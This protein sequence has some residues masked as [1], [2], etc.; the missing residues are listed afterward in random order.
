MKARRILCLISGVH[1]WSGRHLGR[2]SYIDQVAVEYPTSIGRVLAVYRPTCN[3]QSAAA[4]HRSMFGHNQ[5]YLTPV[6]RAWRRL[7]VFASI[8]DWPIVL[9]MPVVNNCFVLVLWRFW[10]KCRKSLRVFSGFALPLSVIGWQNSRHLLNY[11]ETKPI[12]IFLHTLFHAF[13]L[14]SYWFIALFRLL[15]LA[16]VITLVLAS[17]YSIENCSVTVNWTL[18]FQFSLPLF[19]FYRQVI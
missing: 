6:S 13:A 9:F 18:I 14:S 2:L 4:G 8:S 15:W 1:R 16:R 3:E 7:Q 19:T 11:W 17:R 5:S 10:I 12:V